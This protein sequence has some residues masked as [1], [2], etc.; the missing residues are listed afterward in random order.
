ML[1]KKLILILLSVILLLI[2]CEE[3]TPAIETT[4]TPDAAEPVVAPLAA[5]AE[6][7]ICINK[8]VSAHL[9]AN[10]RGNNQTI[11]TEC[12]DGTCKIEE[13][14][15]CSAG[16]KCKNSNERGF[17]LEDCSWERKENC[18][19]G[20]DFESNKCFA[21][22]QTPIINLTINK[23]VKVNTTINSTTNSSSNTTNTSKVAYPTLKLGETVT[24]ND[25]NLSIYILEPERVRVKLNQYKSDWLADG[26]N[27]LFNL[28]QG[29]TRIYIR[30]ILFQPYEGGKRQISYEVNSS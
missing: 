19:F 17:Q 28:T 8:T 26:E 15:I 9:N 1:K 11:W 6:K 4:T 20:C 13:I 21:T 25:R 23:T 16:F 5:C 7:W 27:H 2:S 10:C 29:L 3:E 14:D 12:L 18:E 24:V 30:E 22:N